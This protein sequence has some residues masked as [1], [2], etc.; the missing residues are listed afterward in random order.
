MRFVKSCLL[1]IKPCKQGLIAVL[2]R[3]FFRLPY[4][5]YAQNNVAKHGAGFGVTLVGM[6]EAA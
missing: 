5:P 6:I 1:L 3:V 4:A 2:F